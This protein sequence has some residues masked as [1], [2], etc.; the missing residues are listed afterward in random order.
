MEDFHSSIKEL[1]EL[2]LEYDILS[3]K[4]LYDVVEKVF[5]NKSE[6]LPNLKNRNHA[7]LILGREKEMM[8]SALAKFLNLKKSSVTSII[9]S[10]EKDGLVKR[11]ADPMDR[12]KIWISL[13]SSGYRYMD[14]LEGCVEKFVNVMLEGLVEDEIEE[15]LQS[16][17]SV[18]NLERKIS[19]YVSDN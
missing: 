8:P 3:R 7:I 5:D 16:M 10:L 18:V 4:V 13:T 2:K 9:D 12:R 19:A 17:R 15:M 6:P 11:T 14:V 1:A